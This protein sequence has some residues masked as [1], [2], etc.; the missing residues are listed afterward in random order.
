MHVRKAGSANRRSGV[1][2]SRSP[3]CHK[4]G[5]MMYSV[6]LLHAEW[7][8][9]QESFGRFDCNRVNFQF[10]QVL[11]YFAKFWLNS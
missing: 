5:Y 6:S 2:S 9:L 11:I 1:F 10:G 4:Y 8:K 3:V 7:P